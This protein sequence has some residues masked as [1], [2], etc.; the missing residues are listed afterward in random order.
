M[1]VSRVVSADIL[2]LP[3]TVVAY[4]AEELGRLAEG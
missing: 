3:F 2:E 1:T 4:D